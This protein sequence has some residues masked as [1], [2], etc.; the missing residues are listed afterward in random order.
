[1]AT[2]PAEGPVVLINVFQVGAGQEEAFV[3][4]WKEA[5]EHLRQQ[6]GFVATKLHESLNPDAPNRFVN[7]A[8]WQSAQQYE[9]AVASPAFRQ[10]GQRIRTNVQASSPALYRVVAE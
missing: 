5:H 8:H 10:I 6:D 1:M 2:P 9:A 3:A 7:V 4:G